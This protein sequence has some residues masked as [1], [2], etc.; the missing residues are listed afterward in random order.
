MGREGVVKTLRVAPILAAIAALALL[1]MPAFAM[2]N[3]APQLNC[4]VCHQGAQNHPVKFVVEGLPKVAEPGKLYKLVIKILNGPPSKGAAYGGFALLATAG[5]LVVLDPKDTFITTMMINGTQYK[6]ITH[7]KA[8]SMKR[9]W[10]VGWQAPTTCNGPIKIIVSVIAA[11]GDGSPMGDWYGHKVF[12]VQCGGAAKPTTTTTVIT[13]T[14][15]TTTVITTTVYT[16]SYVTQHNPALAVGV[17]I[18]IFVIVVAGYAL[19]TR[20]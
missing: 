4:V 10:V 16:T 17:A 18:A 11:N 7:T 13:E 1:A 2:S 19:A 15:T 5:K 9:E 3:G 14:V 20:K 12:V 8:G 6:V